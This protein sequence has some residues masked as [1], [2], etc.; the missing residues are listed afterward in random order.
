VAKAK[1]V[2]DAPADPAA[3]PEVTDTATAAVDTTP[4]VT[5]EVKQEAPAPADPLAKYRK[6]V[7]GLSIYNF[8]EVAL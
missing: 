4:A 7:D 3:I 5:P 6:V 8:T 1:P 2:T